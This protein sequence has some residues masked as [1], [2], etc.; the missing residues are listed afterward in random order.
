MFDFLK[1]KIKEKTEQE[2]QKLNSLLNAGKK[3]ANYMASDKA[4]PWKN[5]TV[6]KVTNSL[7]NI[8]TRPLSSKANSTFG[9]IAGGI[10]ETPYTMI[11][12]PAKFYGSTLNAT[13]DNSIYTKQGAK[14]AF[15][16][17]LETGLDIAG[18][19][20]LGKA[21][22]LAKAVPVKTLSQ[23]IKGGAKTG[24]KVGAGY[25]AGYAT[26][27]GLQEN[28]RFPQILKN[29]VKQ[30]A[31]GGVTGGFLGGAIP[32]TSGLTRAIKFDVKNKGKKF[33]SIPERVF[34]KYGTNEGI[35]VNG[36]P[37]RVQLPMKKRTVGFDPHT[38]IKLPAQSNKPAL[39]T[40]E[41][42][43]QINKSFPRPGMNIEDVSGGSKST[44][45][46]FSLPK[47]TKTPLAEILPKERG[48]ISTV[49]NS[50]KTSKEVAM[51]VK[52]TYTPAPNPT[53][54]GT[55]DKNIAKDFEGAVYRAKTE[56]KISKDIQAESLRLIDEL[57]A[58]GRHQDAIDIVEKMSERAT[59]GGQATQV[60]AAFNRLTPDG[61][62]LSAQ[63]Q[64]KKAKEMN[65]NK[66]GDLRLSPEQSSNIRGMA[67]KL[68]TM[69]PGEAKDQAT[70][71]MLEEIA[72]LAPTPWAKKV[73]TLWKAGLLTGIKGAVGGNT[74]GNSAMIML[75]KLSDVPASGIDMA[76]SKLTGQRSKVF[77]LKGI[78]DGA[79]EGGKVGFNN[80]RKGIGSED[81]VNK[82]DYQKT[83]FGKGIL[84][85]TAQKYTDTVF[86]AY[87]ALDRPFYHSAL[88]NSLND[89]A[90][91]EA[92][93]K[94]LSGK[95]AKEFVENLVKE[96]PEE[97]FA[98]A[99]NAAETAVF[100]NKNALGSGLS[101]LKQGLKKHGGS[102]GEIVSEGILPFTGVPSSIATAVH[103]YSPTGMIAETF[104]SLS[105]VKNGGLSQ[106][107]QRK[108]SE[109]LGKGITGTGAMW[110]G[111]K[112]T[113][114][115]QMTLGFPTDAGERALWEQE[116]KTPY[117]ILIGGKWRSLNYMGPIMS[118]LAIGGE[119][120]K[121]DNTGLGAISTGMAGSGKAILGSSPL[122]GMQA[123][124][125][126]VTDP[127]RYGDSY[128][129]N[130]ISSVVP[131]LVKDFAV[132][133]D[134]TQREVNTVGE[135]IQSKIPGAR[136][137]LLPK[138]DVFGQ[139]V[140]RNTSAIGSIIDPFKSSEARTSTLTEELRRLQDS[141]EGATLSKLNKKQK[142]DGVNVSLSPEELDKLEQLSGKVIKPNLE[143]MISSPEYQ[144]LP[145]EDKKKQINDFINDIRKEAKQRVRSE[146]RL[147]KETTLTSSSRNI[148]QDFAESKVKDRQ[149]KLFN[150]KM[151]KL[152]TKTEWINADADQK[153]KIISEFSRMSK[154]SAVAEMMK[155]YSSKLN[156]EQRRVYLKELKQSGILTE[157]IFKFYM[158]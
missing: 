130:Q 96:P 8:N 65:P 86:N 12:S 24:F 89:F 70:R 35:Q 74:I 108:L 97:L 124:M 19:G 98:K 92:K 60:L 146:M 72:R 78:L 68:Q 49:K 27:Q 45:K 11:T 104:K 25:G 39:Q 94:G 59:E 139:E 10:V 21:K 42:L 156:E 128:L 134:K 50:P 2:K 122:Q 138:R 101:G 117:S 14:K 17:A 15:G 38:D 56:T 131:T 100:Q 33:D 113:E 105:E 46:P 58:K 23:V 81:V 111:S 126:A 48:F 135:A 93:N 5:K 99:H 115:G 37:Q 123:G 1:K 43:R 141:G 112:L 7:S 129:R 62:L 3:S 71:D 61:V 150:D 137:L 153:N 13:R 132:A 148:G 67:E 151:N 26:A 95:A 91:V 80:M 83:Y 133:G 109:A 106:E 20:V 76:L 77:T 34:T 66:Y 152:K 52:G 41:A 140:P 87:S 64:I 73:T 84:G 9:K 144:A 110:L 29:S 28:Q 127:Q 85:R 90:M 114:S 125:D 16:G 53:T 119:I 51:G 22:T 149:V 116:G 147:G 18:G 55:A 121:A 4:D 69:V 157:E 32:A 6:Q 145:D 79:V 31:I 158:Q 63:R 47:S 88:K 36:K 54:L 120:Q 30:G 142:I 107:G 82:L 143:K 44:P 57:Q 103:N 40:P 154:S 102:A 136:N 155:E 75:R 118:L